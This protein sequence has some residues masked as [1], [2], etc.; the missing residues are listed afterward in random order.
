VSYRA[1]DDLVEFSLDIAGA[2][3]KQAAIAT[4]RRTL[5]LERG[6]HPQVVLEDAYRLSGPATAA[7][8]HIMTRGAVDSATPGLLRCAGADRPLYI[9]YDG[10]QFDVNVERIAIDDERLAAVWGEAVYRVILRVREAAAEGR[11]Q[12]TMAASE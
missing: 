4:W 2:F 11:W 10:H 12:L 5:R 1:D 8:L 9:H 3:P 7:A 6:A